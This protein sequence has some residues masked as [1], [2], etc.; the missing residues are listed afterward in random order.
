MLAD[1]RI[2]EIKSNDSITFEI[3]GQKIIRTQ[4]WN[5][6]SKKIKEK[7][8]E[9]KYKDSKY[10]IVRLKIE[11]ASNLRNNKEDIEKLCNKYNINYKKN[12]KFIDKIPYKIFETILMYFIDKE[13][14]YIDNEGMLVS[15]FY[16]SNIDFENKYGIGYIELIN[17][18]KRL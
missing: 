7:L 17:K 5:F 8:K 1:D 16:M 3:N 10:A 13:I 6:N 14:S 12:K 9:E 4:F 15:D 2:S 18:G 11:R